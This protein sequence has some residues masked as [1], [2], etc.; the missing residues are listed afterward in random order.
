MKSSPH[1]YILVGKYG[2]KDA[3]YE[4][5]FGDYAKDVVVSEKEVTYE[6]VGMRV[7]TLTEDNQQAI[8]HAVRQLNS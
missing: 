4:M 2:N 8:N 3:P 6:Y 5:I 1:Y 7:V